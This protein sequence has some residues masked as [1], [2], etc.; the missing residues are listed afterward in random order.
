MRTV[1]ISLQSENDIYL[2]VKMEKKMLLNIHAKFLHW[3]QWRNFVQKDIVVL[4][5]MQTTSSAAVMN[6]LIS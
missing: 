5:G 2:R 1:S 4:L 3:N 6:S